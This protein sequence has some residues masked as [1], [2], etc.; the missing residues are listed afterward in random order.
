[1]VGR[2]VEQQNIGTAEQNSGQLDPSTLATGQGAQGGLQDACWK[3]H[4]RGDADPMTGRVFAVKVYEA[5]PG[6]GKVRS[7]RTMAAIGLDD[8]I[9]LV[10]VPAEARAEIGR[11][12]ATPASEGQGYPSG[13]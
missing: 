4:R 10:D 8:D 7:R 6:I 1:M 9:R 3:A 13:P 12:F 11:R 2:F 5:A